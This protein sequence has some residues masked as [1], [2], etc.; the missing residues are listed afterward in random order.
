MK[1]CT[2]IKKR[3]KSV[4]AFRNSSCNS[5]VGGAAGSQHVHGTAIDLSQSGLTSSDKIKVYGIFKL[6]G[7]NG[8]GCYG[9]GHVHFDHGAARKWGSGCPP[10]LSAVGY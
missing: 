2:I 10:E 1:A 8:V 3:L 6:N 9:S 4:S 5:K 7:F